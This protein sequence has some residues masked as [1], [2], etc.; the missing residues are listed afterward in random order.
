MNKIEKLE[1]AIEG[2]KFTPAQKKVIDKLLIGYTIK[3]I[4]KYHISGGQ[5]VWYRE[6]NTEHAGRIYKAFFNT[7]RT[8]KKAKGLDLSE[9][10]YN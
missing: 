7:F 6:G 9:L 10:F 4:N 8:I 2:V 5:M 1:K 3:I